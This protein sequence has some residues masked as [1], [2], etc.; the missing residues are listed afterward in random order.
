MAK[1][2]WGTK[3]EC[4][5]C[6]TRFYD[7][8]RDPATCP[9]CGYTFEIASLANQL[10]R[11]V[12]TSDSEK[13]TPEAEDAVLVDELDVEVDVE[14][15]A[16]DTVLEDDVLEGDDVPLDAIADVAKEDDES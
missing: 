3:R 8:G 4:P 16:D 1:P 2:E 5:K 9:N 14:V 13:A 11:P 15:E 6:K 12:L 10:G 7:L